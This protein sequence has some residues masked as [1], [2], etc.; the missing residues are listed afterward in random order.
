MAQQPSLVELIA[1]HRQRIRPVIPFDLTAGGAV[2]FD[3]T[4]RSADFDQGEIQDVTAFTERLSA[5]VAEAALPVGVGRWNEDR[6]TYRHSPLFAGETER[7]SVHLGVDLFVAAGT[8]VAAPLPARIHSLADNSALGDYGPTVLLEHELGDRRFWTLYGHLGRRA[9]EGLEVGRVLGAGEPFAEVGHVGENGGWPP[10]LHF[11]LI[12]DLLGRSGDFP[13]V[14]AP[15]ERE[16]WI[17]LCPDP[18]VL[19]GIPE[20]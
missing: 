7:R 9:V 13:G 4:E 11:Q 20:L 19:L 3:L 8:E 14:A 12:S 1:A 18:N 10:H 6:M 17:A 2:I 15:S 16:R 5:R